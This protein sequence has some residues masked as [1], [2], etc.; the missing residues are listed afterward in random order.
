[1][2]VEYAAVGGFD[3][4]ASTAIRVN[5]EILLFASA[6]VT[7]L[8]LVIGAIELIWLNRALSDKSFFVKILYKHL[9]YACFFFIIMLLLFPVAASMELN[10]SY[11]DKKVWIKFSNF[12]TSLTSLSTSVQLGVSLLISLLYAEISEN[13]GQNVL[14]NFFTG[15][16]HQPKEEMRI[17]MFLDMKSSTTIAEKLGHIRYFELLKEYY[18]SFSHA[19]VSNCG[20]VY[21]YI[22]DEI[23]ISWEYNR[24]LF[25]NSCIRTFLDMQDALQKRA[26]YFEKTFGV[27]PSFKAGMH[28]G[29]VTTG[30]IGALK[31]EIIFTGDVLN[32]TARIQGLCNKLNADLLI[33]KELI[34][35]LPDDNKFLFTSVGEH[36]LRGRE[37]TIELFTLIKNVEN[38]N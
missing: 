27:I 18:N 38:V 29:L 19:I 33:S 1:M 32:S 13:I 5:G 35:M 21:Q 2:F 36:E 15:K 20:E 7:A 12:L 17:F 28:T 6:A 10:V 3:N 24:G 31:K 8:G 30:E 22:G 34:D 37:E 26:D 16:Y 11:F 9:F 23:V 25:N 14:L 4:V